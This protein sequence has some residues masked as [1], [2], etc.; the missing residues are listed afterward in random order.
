MLNDKPLIANILGTQYQVIIS[1]SKTY[2]ELR[3]L[4]GFIDLNAKKI[5]V[6]NNEPTLKFEFNNNL[7]QTIA[8]ELIHGFLHES[9]LAGNS[10][11]VDAWAVNEEMVDWFALQVPKI[12][13]TF[14]EIQE[15]IKSGISGQPV[16]I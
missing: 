15:Q 11:S 10:N 8:H 7:Q 14:M 3:E 9:G 13:H 12:R 6:E 5:V 16:N 4:D 2:P 1:D